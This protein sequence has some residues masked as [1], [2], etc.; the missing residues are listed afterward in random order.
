ME[1]ADTDPLTT[2]FSDLGLQND[3]ETD[4]IK[5]MCTKT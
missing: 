3:M 4:A 5:K 1:A 2:E